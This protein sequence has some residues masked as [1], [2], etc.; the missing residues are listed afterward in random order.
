[1]AILCQL[2]FWLCDKSFWLILRCLVRSSLLWFCV[3]FCL[4]HL[5]ICRWRRFWSGPKLLHRLLSLHTILLLVVEEVKKIVLSFWIDIVLFRQC[6][7][8]LI[9]AESCFCFRLWVEMI[10]HPG[11]DRCPKICLEPSQG[12]ILCSLP[13]PVVSGFCGCLSLDGFFLSVWTKVRS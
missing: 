3:C 10:L 6:Q 1:M 9:Q 12:M 11:R 7:L 13:S 5:T 2:H 4:G 8:V